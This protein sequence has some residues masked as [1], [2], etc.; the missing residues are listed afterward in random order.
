MDVYTLRVG[1]AGVHILTH[2]QPEDAGVENLV[3]ERERHSTENCGDSSDCEGHI[4]DEK[5]VHTWQAGNHSAH[6]PPDGVGDP[7]CRN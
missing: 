6:D 2:G 1:Y 3:S 7:Y 5:S 4:V